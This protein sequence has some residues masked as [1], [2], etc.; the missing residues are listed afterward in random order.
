[1]GAACS[2]YC[3]ESVSMVKTEVTTFV[4]S[5]MGCEVVTDEPTA[6]PVKSGW[7]PMEEQAVAEGDG[8]SKFTLFDADCKVDSDC[9]PI[10]SWTCRRDNKCIRH[11]LSPN[12][13][14]KCDVYNKAAAW[15]AGEVTSYKTCTEESMVACSASSGTTMAAACELIGLGPEDPMANGC[16]LALVGA[17]TWACTEMCGMA[18]NE[19]K[20]PTLNKM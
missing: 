20:Q 3:G 4:T 11:S 15:I 13:W 7:W 16:A 1:M 5:T 17:L 12:A 18:M 10:N 8:C 14:S 6:A 9:C 2:S 19:I